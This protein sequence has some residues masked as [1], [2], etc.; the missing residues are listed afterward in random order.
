MVAGTDVARQLS[1]D[2]LRNQ[3]WP[4]DTAPNF[5][6]GLRCAWETEPLGVRLHTCGA[7]LDP[8]VKTFRGGGCTL[9]TAAP[10]KALYFS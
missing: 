7:H 5:L 1:V 8:S 6:Q 2:R 4:L 10:G 3:G 9:P